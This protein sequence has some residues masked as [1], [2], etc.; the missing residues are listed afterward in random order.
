MNLYFNP[1]LSKNYKSS[2]QKVRALSENWMEEN[3]Y[4]P[5]CGHPRIK[6]LPNNSPVAD[7]RCEQCGEVYELKSHQG[8][9][10]KKIMDG[11]YSTMIKRI[12]NNTNTDLFVL[13]YTDQYMVHDLFLIPRFFFV[14]EIIERREP[15]AEGARRAGWVGC[16]ILYQNIPNQAK[17][18]VIADGIPG[19]P[20]DVV[21]GYNHIKQLQNNNLD[22][23][24]W[25]ID[26]LNCI[27]QIDAEVF[28]LKDV[29]EYKDILKVKHPSNNNIEAKI[30]QQLQFLRDKGFI[31]FFGNGYYRKL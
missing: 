8:K 31:E 27:D 28:T 5:N 16:N 6:S 13:Q 25:L 23:R 12:T 1:E 17:I 15:L 7:F 3:M 29:Y 4:C 18:S 2:S 20:E 19:K 10:G 11:A 9:Y 14:P 21:A 30:R 24:G 26:V 22:S